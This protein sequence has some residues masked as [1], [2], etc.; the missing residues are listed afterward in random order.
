MEGV[1]AFVAHQQA[2]VA[3]QPGGVWKLVEW[4]GTFQRP[5]VSIVGCRRSSQ[6]QA[7]RQQPAAGA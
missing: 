1:V 3:V 4:S 6:S 2:T 7:K 5:G